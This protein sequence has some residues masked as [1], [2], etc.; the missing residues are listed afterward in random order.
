MSIQIRKT[1][2]ESFR[3]VWHHK[4]EWLR[5][6]F[7]PI[8]IYLVGFL[9]MSIAYWSTGHPVWSHEILTGQMRDYGDSGFL[10]ALAN[11]IYYITHII[12]II[13]LYINGFRYALFNEGGEQWWTLTLNWRFVKMILYYVLIIL[14][15]AV[16]IGI[17]VAITVGAHFGIGN[18]ALTI[19]I[20]TLLTL[21]GFYLII[22]LASLTFLLIAIDQT[23][24][25][26][27]GWHLLKKNVLR[28]IGLMFLI[29][30][31]IMGIALL[32]FAILGVL[33]WILGLMSPLLAG[34]G[35]GLMV[36][37][38]LAIWLFSMAISLKSLALVYTALEDKSL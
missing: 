25:L 19:L 15:V 29:G 18:V 5:V 13:C 31:A 38:G 37:L 33:T 8:A 36:L 4:L 2:K 7:A 23:A 28:L 34:V 16:Y 12:S 22:R 6:F 11:A 26:K 3:N 1:F 20:G 35:L 30:L 9:F 24:P 17:A 14:I 32:G 10:I 21:Y 27:T